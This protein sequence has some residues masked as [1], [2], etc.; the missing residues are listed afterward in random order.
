MIIVFVIDNFNVLK[1]GTNMTAWRFVEALKARGHKVRV[2]SSGVGGPG[3]Y[4]VR[5]RYI[6]IVSAVAK[7]Q[8]IAFS[9]PEEK[10]FRQAFAG[11]D[12]VHFFMPWKFA[13]VGKK[14]A[15][16]MGIPTTAA[17]HVQ[18]ENITFGIGLGGTGAPIARLIY[19]IFK[20]KFYRNFDHIH[21]PSRFI[22]GE[23]KK[24]GY[25]AKLHVISNGVGPNF[26]AS[27]K[28][29]DHDGYFN[30]LMTGRY[31]ME[32]R[33]DALIKAIA[34]SAFRDKIKL[35]LAGAGPRE[36]KLRALAKKLQFPVSFGFLNQSDLIE[37]IRNTDLY[38]H[39]AEVEIEAISCLE[40]IACGVVPV[41]ADSKKSAT[42]QFAIDE[43]SL[44]KSGNIRDLRDKIDYWLEH[45]EERR[46]MALKYRSFSKIYRLDYCVRKAEDMFRETIRDKRDR[47][48]VMSPEG[49]R[50]QKQIV[51]P[52]LPRILSYAFYFG[53]AIPLLSV[54]SVLFLD[55]RIKNRAKLVK[56]LKKKGAVTVSNHVHTLDS[57]MAAI[58]L[59]PKKT[60]FTS[61]PDNF[62]MPLAGFFVRSLGAVP[63]P[64]TPGENRIF[65]HE[66][67]HAARNG[68]FVH[69]FP[70]G[71]LVKKDVN[72][73][74]LKKGAFHLAVKA[75]VPVIPLA[76]TFRER[77][78]GVVRLLWKNEIALTVGDPI[79]PDL[80]LISKEAITDLQSR[81]EITMAD[82]ISC[83]LPGREFSH[84]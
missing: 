32:K 65:F 63:V 28:E 75:Q 83:P 51:R 39:A 8:S 18:P 6:P 48:F 13:I 66:L 3:M 11:A 43:R 54:F 61:I 64:R 7:K 25:K 79:Y 14:I 70:E 38:V 30:I 74:P 16:E 27:E 71:E 50:Y 78:R 80:R 42:R 12:V 36:K 26:C 58:T 24:R 44:F 72:L 59:F 4:E 57:A 56:M 33:Q 67:S 84:E 22:A 62:V 23:L 19:H 40:A 35:T 76:I 9:F 69:L 82:M 47:E 68:R 77:Q 41:I 1:N 49:R 45:D 53:V 52:A 20:K 29:K 37:T 10:V 46:E 34:K 17:F 21:C 2:V 60:V 5:E 31:A 73:R 15:D 81:V 55:F